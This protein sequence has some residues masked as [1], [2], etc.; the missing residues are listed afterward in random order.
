[1]VFTPIHQELALPP[2]ELSIDLLQS[3]IK[4]GVVETTHLDW[5]RAFYNRENKKWHEEAAKDIAAMAN[6]G[7]GWVVFGVAENGSN[8]SATELFPLKW[9]SSEEQRILNVAYTKVDPPV[10][11]IETYPIEIDE[12]NI[13][14]MRVPDSLD[15]PHFARKDD[16]SLIAPRRNGSH[17]VFM[18]GRE[19]ERA[20]R[21]RFQ[22][23]HD[24]E[25]AINFVFEKAATALNADDGV[26][27]VVVAV[28]AEPSNLESPESS[29]LNKYIDLDPD[30]AFLQTNARFQRLLSGEMRKGMR[31]WLLRSNAADPYA[32]RKFFCDDGSLLGCYRLGNLETDPRRASYYPVGEPNHCMGLH[33]ESYLADFGTTLREFAKDRRTQGIFRLRA[34]LVGDTTKPIYIRTTSGFGHYLLDADYS[35]P[36]IVPEQVTIDF[37]PLASTAELLAV[38]RSVATD[39]INQ[40]GIRNLQVLREEKGTL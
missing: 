13:V 37:E 15:A 27:L 1:M 8:N 6:S 21:E 40:G 29:E 25:N 36:I 18:N 23:S 34:G 11:G 39:L 5:K 32:Y 4:A 33:I 2:G 38:L 17:T 24:R 19:I 20:F 3:A 22:R 10:L 31:S 9:D 30:P 7:G 35:E 28:P 12:G 16:G 26:C 14:F